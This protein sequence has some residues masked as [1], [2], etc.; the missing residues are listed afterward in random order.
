MWKLIKLV[1]GKL[2]I[3]DEWTKK[4]RDEIK[5][6]HGH[7]EKAKILLEKFQNGKSINSCIKCGSHSFCS[8][9][10][11]CIYY[12]LGDVKK[13][14]IYAKKAIRDFEL[15]NSQWNATLANWIYGETYMLLGREMPAQR[16][17]T[18]TIKAFNAMGKEFRWDDKYEARN[19]CIKYSSKIRK[20]LKYPD[21]NW[22]GKVKK[23]GDKFSLFSNMPSSYQS[24]FS[25]ASRNPHP[26]RCSQIIFPVHSQIRAGTEGNFI[27][28]SEPDLDAALDK[29]EF[30]GVV[31]YFYNLR[32]EG[33]PIIFSPRVHRWF[34]VEGNSMNRAEPVAIMDGDYVLAIDLNLSN[35]SPRMG[36]IVIANLYN[37]MPDERAGVIKK[38][39]REGLESQSSGEYETILMEQVNVR[40]VAIAVAKAT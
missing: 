31:H 28:E 2:H 15:D 22:E 39:T 25:S 29:L 7:P 11:A 5:I 14:H 12:E 24:S 21:R 18:K 26:W 30:N 6:L 1:L 9:F 3:N 10:L 19:Q 40:G 4:T 23:K 38:Y 34:R 33:N 8:L 32:E 16:E 37:P 36:D 20:R 13:V 17:L 27:F 35:M